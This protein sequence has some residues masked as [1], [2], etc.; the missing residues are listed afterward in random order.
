MLDKAKR[1]QELQDCNFVELLIKCD[2]ALFGASLYHKY[3]LTLWPW[4]FFATFQLACRSFFT[5]LDLARSFF[6]VIV[7][8]GTFLYSSFVV[9]AFQF[10]S[11]LKCMVSII[12]TQFLKQRTRKLNFRPCVL[13]LVQI[14]ITCHLSK[15][16]SPEAVYY[17]TNSFINRSLY[18]HV[19]IFFYLVANVYYTNNSFNNRSLYL[20]VYIC[21]ILLQII[22]L[23]V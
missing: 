12:Y 1:Q 11:Y 2:D 4:S 19:Y 8:H 22:L 16:G 5:Y 23:Y 10:L 9:L 18:L 3:C 17:P 13:N 7:W 15:V 6:I 20:Y 14:H 21:S